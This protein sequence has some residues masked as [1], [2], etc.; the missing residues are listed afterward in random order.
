MKKN[1][2]SVFSIVLFAAIFAVG[3]QDNP[4]I[5]TVD[6]ITAEDELIADAAYDDVFTEVDAIMNLMDQFGY[7]LS[8]LKS[9]GE[10][11]T[12]PVISIVTPPG[13]F[14]PRTVIVDYG[15]GCDV[16]RNNTSRERIR[17]GKIIIKVSGRMW[18]PGSYR[19]VTFEDF[20]INDHQV[21]GKRTV[22]NEG[23]WDEGEY[24]GL[25]YFSVVL[26]GGKVTRPDGQEI[27]KDVNRTRTFVEGFDTKWDTRDDIWHINGIATGVNRKG[28]AFSREITSPLWKE[29]G[30]RFITQGTVL[31]QAE[32]RPDVVL[33]Y[34]DGECDPF[35]TVTVNGETKEI[36]LKKW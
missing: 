25:K 34:G 16:S 30:C 24:E 1:W 35:A 20:Y 6:L 26:E 27:T 15:D 13:S 28:I 21:E 8:A 3:C 9:A 31:I 5:Q 11:D 22:T 7:E 18:K 33:D 19:E 4:S 2:I 32:G 12:C 17:K 23:L 10:L 14:W 29:V 36:R